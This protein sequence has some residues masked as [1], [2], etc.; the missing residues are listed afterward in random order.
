MALLYPPSALLATANP[1][2][3]RQLSKHCAIYH[4]ELV[5]IEFSGWPTQF[6][7]YVLF[8]KPLRGFHPY[9]SW[10]LESLQTSVCWRLVK[11]ERPVTLVNKNLYL[12]SNSRNLDQSKVVL[13]EYKEAQVPSPS[14]FVFRHIE[15]TTL[16]LLDASAILCCTNTGINETKQ[17]KSETSKTD[18]INLPSFQ[19]D[20]IINWQ[21]DRNPTQP[22]VLETY[23]RTTSHLAFTAQGNLVTWYH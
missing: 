15:D 23:L 10:S 12:E 13:E 8:S 20:S 2:L 9:Y 11:L 18:K 7:W 14:F 17:P 1:A 6:G 5:V 22:W 4:V 3:V 19:V 21:R 16:P